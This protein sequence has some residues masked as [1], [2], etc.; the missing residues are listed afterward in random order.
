MDIRL[1]DINTAKY[2]V[3]NFHYSKN[4]PS[5]VT[6]NYGLFID[7]EC[8]AAACYGPCVSRHVPKDWVELRRLVKSENSNFILSQFLA[9]TLKIMRKNVPAILSWADPNQAHHG[10]IYQATNWI[11]TEQKSGCNRTFIDELGNHI[12]PRTVYA[13]YGTQSVPIILGKFPKWSAYIPKTKYRYLMPGLLSKSRCLE[14]LKTKELPY[15]KPGKLEKGEYK[16]ITHGKESVYM[17][18]EKLSIEDFGEKLISSGDLDPVYIALHK[19]EMDEDKLAN[20]LIAYWCLY[21]PGV[22]SYLSEQDD[23]WGMLELAAHNDTETPLGGRWPRA[24]E[25]RHW[26]GA[27]AIASFKSLRDFGT[28]RE[29]IQMLSESKTQGPNGTEILMETEYSKVYNRAM[30]FKGFGPWIAF[31]IADML[32]R[33]AIAPIDFEQS[34]VFMFKDPK[35]AALKLYRDRA[36]IPDGMKLKDEK[37]AIDEVVAHLRSHFEEHAAPP[38]Y[39]RSIGFQE[40]ETVLCKWKSH[41]NGHYP[42]Y[43][44]LNEIRKGCDEWTKVSSTASE[45]NHFLP[46]APAGDKV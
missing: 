5:N 35:K 7:D 45:F 29:I 16:T 31:K 17:T 12:H 41:M 40:V 10:G 9:K 24:A 34:D 39:D 22:A 38:L 20:W 2:L 27:N 37:K 18:Y 13:R 44:D 11:F 6:I 32:E 25:R 4:L 21:H 26:R 14:I 30:T 33:L 23:F 46:V 42:L 43:N 19:M 3:E 1:V 36:G 15:P 28:P 8:V